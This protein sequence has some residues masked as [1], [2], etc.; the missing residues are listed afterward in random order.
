MRCP[1]CGAKMKQEQFCPF[2]N[3]TSDQVLGASNKKVKQYRKNGS[4]DLIYFTNVLPSDVSR[5]K[6]ILYTIFFG[7]F[8][9][10]HFYVN[11]PNRAIFSV[12]TSAGSMLFFILY[13]LI[14]FKTKFAENLFSIVYQLIF[15]GMAVNVI[16]WILDVFAV[17]FKTFKVP[18]VMKDKE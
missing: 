9:V 3:V 13:L 16:I 8:G 17:L 10:N 14:D 11:R 18:V 6:L 4:K 5:L 1:I 15:Y 12:V 7:L 2:C